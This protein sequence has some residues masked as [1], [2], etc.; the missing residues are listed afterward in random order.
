MTQLT[1][2]QHGVLL[3]NPWFAGLPD[4]VRAAIVGCAHTRA[5][6]QGERLFSRGEP[7]NFVY[8]VLEGAIRISGT[9]REGREAVLTLYEPGA[10]FGDLS[11]LDGQPRTH[12]AS[13]YTRAVLLALGR[14]DFERLLST[15]PALARELLRLQ[16][17]RLR[18]LL[19][20]LEAHATQSL[21]QRFASRLLALAHAYGT[22]TARGL[23]IELHLSQEL[24]AQLTGVTRQRVNQVLKVWEQEGLI[25]QNYGRMVLLDKAALGR[26]A[27]D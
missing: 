17:T 5:L 11:L 20:A 1:E 25:E 2:T 9:S 14:V 13:A 3:G 22:H 15:Y 18:S 8:A 23:S 24:L 6:V 4:E 19:S 16:G 12:D 26:L 7:G 10:W 27:D 21:E